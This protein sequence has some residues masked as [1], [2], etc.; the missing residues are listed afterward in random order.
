MKKIFGLIFN[1][2]V[3]AVLGLLAI[4]LVIWF[5]GPLIAVAEYRPLE[6]A[7]VRWIVIAIVIFGYLAKI[8]WRMLK[9]K[10][11]N[12]RL[13]EGLLRQAPAQPSPQTP[14]SE[15]VAMLGGRFKE[16]M[17]VLK[18]AR[19]GSKDKANGLAAL[20][21]RQY[22]YQLPWY[23][24]IG[25]PGSGKT[26]ALINSGLKFPLAEQFGQEAIRG[27]GGTRNCDWWFTDEAVL[28]D[29]AGRYTTHETD[30]EVDSAAWTGFLNLLK[31]FR[32]R[33]PINGVLL[34]ISVADL[35]QQTPAQREIHAQA[36]RK[37]V[38]ELHQQLGIRFPVYVLITKADLL[39]GFSE[40]FSKLGAEERA[41]V[42]GA[43]FPFRETAGEEP[44]LSTF[45]NEFGALEQRL[46]DRVIDRLQEERNPQLRA[47]IYAFPQQFSSIKSVLNDF[48]EK[49]FAPSRFEERP[50]LRGIYFT[51]GTQEG[52]PIERVMGTLG[53]A[54]RLEQKLLAP[55]KPS[56]KS[57][58]LTRLLDSVIFTESGLAGANLRLERRRSLLQWM[59][60]TLAAAITI[61]G[62]SAWAISYSRN[63]A[64][65][66]TVQ[67][68][69]PQ[70]A[71]QVAGLNVTSDS[72][73]V[74]L[75]PILQAV[76]N[77][78]YTSNVSRDSVPLSMGFGL[79]QGDQFAGAA[80]NVYRRLLQ[81]VF[82]PK[83]S[84]RIE[85]QLRSRSNDNVESLY[86]TL[87]AYL[88]LHDV[89]HFDADALQGYIE[90]DWEQ[91]LPHD[92]TTEQRVMLG[93]HLSALLNHGA[94]AS[95]ILANQRLVAD[96]RAS[97]AR[98]PLAE[99]VYSRLKRLDLGKDIPEFTVATSAGPSAPLIFA[100][101]SGKPL[102]KGVSGMFSYHG[103]AAFLKESSSVANQLA[104]EEGWV[105]GLPQQDRA[106]LLDLKARDALTQEVRRLYL[107]EY[108]DTWEAFID[109]IRLVRGSGMAQTIQQARVLAA[110]GSPLRQLLLAIVKEVTLVRIDNA[111]KDIARKTQ[112]M[113]SK[114][115]DTVS[116]LVSGP[117]RSLTATSASMLRPEAVVDDRFSGLRDYV[118]GSA[119]G[120][121]A[122][123]D[124][125]LAIIGEL[126]SH[127]TATELAVKGGNPPPPSDLPTKAK[128]EAGRLPEPAKSLLATLAVAGQNQGLAAMRTN[129][130][131]A[132]QA[133]ISDFCVKA[134]V[135]RYPFVK[136]SQRNVTQ[137]DFA[138]VFAPGGLL[139]E[140]FQKN[141]AALVDTSAR[142]WRFRQVGDASI[143]GDSGTLLQFQR[144]Q[145]IRD[146]FFRSGPAMNLRLDFK[147]IA[148]DVSISQFI[149]DVDGQIVKYS[150]GPQVPQPVQWPGPRG[151]TQVRVQIS[152][153]LTRG[154]MGPFE[155]PW[156]LFRMFDQ[157]QID[158]TSQPEKF[159]ATFVVDGR[160]AQF[161][162]LASS[163]RNPFRLR[164]LEQ[165]QCPGNL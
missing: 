139:D 138:R 49:V 121:P 82:L 106:K 43:S 2:W 20:L 69:I 4:S 104:A 149:L 3:M 14:G 54:L 9:A 157:V 77:L 137:E 35:L 63:K 45:L 117:Q 143:G 105:L 76:Q 124:G 84:L 119:P 127:L 95:P 109:D 99:R 160:K 22:I 130:D 8:A 15:E 122:P 41:Q 50:L 97:L 135:G 86:E 74:K 81:G 142:P 53:R 61:T 165:F 24:F 17:S 18:Q 96:A 156:A 46:N 58:F 148:M 87:K 90:F 85:E 125:T 141:L 128:A 103:Y 126:Y 40:F 91:N 164:E 23:M 129:L 16:A 112:D 131:Q 11:T 7:T 67:N 161:E 39:A 159:L 140:F 151:S 110:P 116:R 44:V 132:L 70:I 162:I 66:A 163:V 158:Q 100:R 133:S 27:V 38:Q 111:D 34:T 12:T 48:L 88:M 6:S 56:G 92:V 26:T 83:L 79:H 72:D 153:P 93:E 19:L 115:K 36:L 1:R 59:G 134:I 25:A 52:N 21:G 57:F 102:N 30:Q 154:G 51:S 33:R 62:I 101:A 107:T 65:I 42:W 10:T 152:P 68:K 32:P 108:A 89:E 5:G 144:A 145:T 80:N 31:K 78:P 150:H 146:V 75:L 147:P 55:Q 118:K 64:Y 136:S 29:T 47:L 73:V 60:L 98:T 120:Q 94:V 114:T 28:I 71:K 155:G 123:I 37:R 13:F 113:L